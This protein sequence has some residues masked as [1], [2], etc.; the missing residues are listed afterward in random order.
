MYNGRKIF[1]SFF[2]A[3]VAIAGPALQAR[4]LDGRSGQ[5]LPNIIFFLADDLGVKCV[6]AYGGKGYRTP[7]LDRLAAEGMRFDQCYAGP[8]CTPSRVALMTGKDSKNPGFFWIGDQDW[9]LDY[10]GKLFHAA[11]DPME[12]KPIRPREDTAESAPI[13]KKLN[14]V[15]DRLEIDCRNLWVYADARGRREGTQDR[16][17]VKLYGKAKWNE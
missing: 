6:G 10:T 2:L 1:L 17:Q 4:D 15:L 5:N 7:N 16:R 11:K 13:R 12:T 8:S 9:K 3:S 14:A